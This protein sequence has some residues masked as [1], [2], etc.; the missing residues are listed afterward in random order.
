MVLAARAYLEQNALLMPVSLTASFRG[1]AGPLETAG[2]AVLL[3][4]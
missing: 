2:T 4:T 1:K 3:L